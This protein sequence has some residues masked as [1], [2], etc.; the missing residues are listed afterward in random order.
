M[1]PE[2][3]SQEHAGPCRP[4]PE[5]RHRVD[6]RQRR[7]L[8]LVRNIMGSNSGRGAFGGPQ[9]RDRMYSLRLQQQAADALQPAQLLLRGERRRRP[10]REAFGS[11]DPAAAYLRTPQRKR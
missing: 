3:W 5:S 11:Y 9:P 1:S 2:S 6:D 10:S 8:A 7:E 4:T